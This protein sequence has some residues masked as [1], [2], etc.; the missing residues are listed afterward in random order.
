MQMRDQMKRAQIRGL[1]SVFLLRV[2]LRALRGFAVAFWVAGRLFALCSPC[3]RASVVGNPGYAKS[4]LAPGSAVTLT[5]VPTAMGPV[6]R[7]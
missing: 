6:A 2:C 1:S 5:S 4:K 3:L 7:S